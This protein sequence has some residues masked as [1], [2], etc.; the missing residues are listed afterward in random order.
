MSN[1]AA[2]FLEQ[3]PMRALLDIPS[4]FLDQARAL[5]Y[6]CYQAARYEEAE[7]LCK[8]LLAA[9]HRSWWP[10]SLYAAVLRNQGRLREALAQIDAGLRYEPAQPKLLAM[11]TELLTLV[12]AVESRA[13]AKEGA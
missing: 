2:Q 7:I 11:K 1:A 4:A 12:D 3:T 10:Y 13:A 5:A 9:D 6:R 8:G